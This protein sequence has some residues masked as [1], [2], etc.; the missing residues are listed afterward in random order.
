MI[1]IIVGLIVI[2]ILGCAIGYIIRAKKRGVHCIG[3]PSGTS[4]NS[5]CGECSG[6]SSLK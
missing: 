2:V 5:G 3:C 4:C 1:D 6:C